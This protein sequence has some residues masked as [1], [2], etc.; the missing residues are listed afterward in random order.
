[1]ENYV[2]IKRLPDADIGTGVI[3]DGAIQGYVYQRNTASTGY[4]D[5]ILTKE[6][7]VNN[8]DFFAKESEWP[9]Y[10][11]YHNPVFRRKDI[12]DLINECFGDKSAS[13]KGYKISASKEL[14]LFQQ[15]LR[16][17]GDLKAKEYINDKG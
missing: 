12:L 16:E 4:V 14:Y 3:W 10:Y 13:G 9:D 6:Q 7:V 11:S 5:A 17:L 2:V 15:K 1:M 8:H